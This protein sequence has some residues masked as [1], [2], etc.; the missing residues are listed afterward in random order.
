M[1]TRV[2]R[3]GL[4]LEQSVPCGP[5]NNEL[6]SNALKHGFPED[7][8]GT[9]RVEVTRAA[10]RDLVVQV[11]DDGVG[12][13]AGFEATQVATLGL[14]LVANPAGQ[15]RGRLAPPAR[16]GPAAASCVVS[17]LPASDGSEEHA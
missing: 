10:E 12:L 4:P 13:P 11:C 9:V 7:R 17:P 6:V 16:P 8:R 1:E 15:L 2:A 14:R 3:L 5:I